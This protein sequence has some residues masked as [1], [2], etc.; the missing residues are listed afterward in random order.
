MSEND[1]SPEVIAQRLGVSLE[2]Y[3]S[4]S[5]WTRGIYEKGSWGQWLST[6]SPERLAQFRQ[7]DRERKKAFYEKHKEEISKRKKEYR[8]RNHERLTESHRCDVCGG[9]YIIDKKQLHLRTKK[10]SRCDA[11]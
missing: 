6:M 1:N 2:T 7:K 3:M 5:P 11:R 10:R 4:W 9:S 8:E